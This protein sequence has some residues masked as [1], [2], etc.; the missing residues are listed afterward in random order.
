MPKTLAIL[1][2]PKSVAGSSLGR[3]EKMAG[4]WISPPPPTTESI[5]PAKT[6]AKARMASWENSVVKMSSLA[7]GV[8]PK[9]RRAT[10]SRAR[11]AKA[12]IVHSLL[13]IVVV[14]AVDGKYTTPRI[15]I[16]RELLNFIHRAIQALY[17][18]DL[19]TYSIVLIW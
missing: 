19:C 12:T 10:G 18:R 6:E 3:T 13:W 5:N 7:N 15:V 1:F 9:H 14:K 11:D 17:S 16:A 8:Q 4:I 2:V